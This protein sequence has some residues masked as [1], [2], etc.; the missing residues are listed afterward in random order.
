MLS[1]LK[2][3]FPSK[4]MLIVALKKIH[5]TRLA[6]PKLW[7]SSDIQKLYFINNVGT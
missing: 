2:H 6:M 7:I 4:K 5:A 1:N 3:E